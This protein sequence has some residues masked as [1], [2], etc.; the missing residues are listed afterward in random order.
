MLNA[1][2]KAEAKQ[3]AVETLKVR[4]RYP[5]SPETALTFCIAPQHVDEDRK[6]VIQ[7]VIVRCGLLLAF[8]FAIH[9]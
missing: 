9:I 6:M 4:P 2:V 1:P 8:C 7:A 3:E 5:R